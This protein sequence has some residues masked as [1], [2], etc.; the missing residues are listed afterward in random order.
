MR[1]MIA[2]R[3][4]ACTLIAG[5]LV[6]P[7]FAQGLIKANRLSA[8]LA[9]E[10]VAAAVNACAKQNQFVT[11]IILDISGVQQATLRG[12]GAGIHTVETADHKAYTAVTFKVDTIE[13]VERAKTGV[14]SSAITKVPRLLLAQGA[15]VIKVG[16]EVIGA[17]GVS[18]ARGNDIDTQ[19]A[20][21]GIEQI[22]DRIK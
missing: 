19:C 13:L 4:T 20:R 18:G 8:A 17:I 21:T 10:A 1:S 15:V 16:D 5:A 3:A 14:V 6:A 2:F 22:R 9:S 7:V 12:D 11:A